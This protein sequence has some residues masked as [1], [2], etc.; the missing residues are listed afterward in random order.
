MDSDYSVSYLGSL[1]ADSLLVRFAALETL[2]RTRLWRI[3]EERL[4]SALDG[5]VGYDEIRSY[6]KTYVN[7]TLNTALLKSL[8]LIAERSRQVQIYDGLV[9]HTDE[10]VGR[11]VEQL[12]ALQEH[13]STVFRPQSS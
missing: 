1:D 10:R 4:R 2:D 7:G 12:P 11:I 6:L 3:T 13:I 8:D 5:G 9:L